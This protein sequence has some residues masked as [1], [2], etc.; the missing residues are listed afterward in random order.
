[1]RNDEFFEL[2]SFYTF[3]FPESH[4]KQDELRGLNIYRNLHFNN[5][6]M[7]YSHAIFTQSLRLEKPDIMS[8][9]FSKNLSR[10]F[11][12]VLVIV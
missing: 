12:P 8:V 11:A 6:D 7:P 9:T 4:F 3:K 1:M 5:N 2:K 10:V